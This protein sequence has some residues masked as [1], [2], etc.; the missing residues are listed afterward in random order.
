MDIAFLRKHYPTRGARW[1][2]QKLSRTEYG[3]RYKAS[4]LK[5]RCQVHWSR[6]KKTSSG[7][8]A[9][10][11]NQS[12]VR[13]FADLE[14]YLLR[15]PNSESV[16]LKLILEAKFDLSQFLSEL[17]EHHPTIVEVGQ[18]QDLALAIRTFQELKRR[19]SV[20]ATE[21]PE[22]KLHRT[23]RK[24]H[25]TAQK[26]RRRKTSRR[27]KPA[28]ARKTGSVSDQVRIILHSKS[29]AK[30]QM[31][32]AGSAPQL[33]KWLKRQGVR[34][35][36][37]NLIYILRSSYSLG[38]REVFGGQ[39]SIRRP[40]RKSVQKQRRKYRRTAKDKL[41][42]VRKKGR[43]SKRRKFLGDAASAR[44][45]LLKAGSLTSL[46]KEM[47]CDER[48]LGTFLKQQYGFKARDVLAQKT[49]GTEKQPAEE[50]G[51]P[52][53]KVER[54]LGD[55]KSAKTL[56]QA[57]G[58]LKSLAQEIGC[59]PVYLGVTLTR[60]YGI[61]ARQVLKGQ[62]S[63]AVKPTKPSKPGKAEPPA[64]EPTGKPI[65]E[66]HA[67]LK[68]PASRRRGLL[69]LAEQLKARDLGDLVSKLGKRMDI[70]AAKLCR[71][72]GAIDVG[73]TDEYRKLVAELAA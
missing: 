10:S 20:S 69:K 63:S 60:V 73:T 41:A 11:G 51:Q 38:F 42:P 59:S 58:S 66:S 67:F 6:F 55:A 13:P 68:L 29:G 25:L 1:V 19:Y 46:A 50:S 33:A 40:K 22:K 14:A 57:A 32:A 64:G 18:E 30:R 45:K 7:A 28:A 36:V 2:A 4:V 62:R 23:P 8:G 43:I 31:L 49:A 72:A 71:E 35:E 56:L 24:K 54:Y 26:P 9:A 21:V 65:N 53:S 16:F 52:R 15:Q 37:P 44:E 12:A 48:N 39:T 34:V 61:S 70:E 47:G 5:V 3:V 27:R 17:V